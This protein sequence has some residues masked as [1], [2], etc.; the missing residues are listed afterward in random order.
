MSFVLEIKATLEMFVS[1]V[2]SWYLW[3]HGTYG[4]LRNLAVEQELF[5]SFCHI[6]YICVSI[7]S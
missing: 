7:C 1:A 4:N 2:Q 6:I 5:Q 3:F